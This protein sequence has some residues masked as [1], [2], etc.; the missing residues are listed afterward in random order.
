MLGFQARGVFDAV[1]FLDKK[2]AQYFEQGY[3]KPVVAARQKKLRVDVA[4][5]TLV[6]LEGRMPEALVQR[7]LS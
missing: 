7:F 1:F 4:G 6:V 3:G 2:C 5:N